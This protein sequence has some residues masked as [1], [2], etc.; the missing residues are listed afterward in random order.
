M[1]SKYFNRKSAKKRDYHIKIE[2]SVEGNDKNYESLEIVVKEFRKAIHR[3]N[4]LSNE[5]YSY[6]LKMEG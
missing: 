3:V 5:K 4:H 6:E 2:I 1:K